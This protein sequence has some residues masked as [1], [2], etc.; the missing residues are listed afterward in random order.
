[1]KIYRW[2]GE[3][4]YCD[5]RSLWKTIRQ[6]IAWFGGWEKANGEGWQFR[7]R[8]Y[9]R[10]WRWHDPYPLSLFGHRVTFFGPWLNIKL[11]GGYLVWR[12]KPSKALNSP[13]AYISWDGTPNK[14]HVWLLNPP[15]EIQDAVARHEAE[16]D[17]LRARWD[18]EAR[19]SES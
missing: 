1:M 6:W 10:G 15:K 12:W 14:A 4:W 11:P 13:Y 18:E 2:N 7:S 8:S 19:E 5:R 3:Y 17:Q 9:A 16:M